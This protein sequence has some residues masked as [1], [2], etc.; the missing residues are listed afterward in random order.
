[1]SMPSRTTSEAPP[2]VV[3]AT[4]R[5]ASPSDCE[6][7][8]MAGL[9][10]MNDMS[11][12]S[13]NSASI[14]SVPELN[15]VSSMVDVVADGGL[16]EAFFDAD[17]RR[18]VGDVREVAKTER[19]GLAAAHTLGP[20]RSAR[21]RGGGGRRTIGLG[22]PVASVPAVVVSAAVPSAAVALGGGGRVAGG[23]VVVVTA[24]GGEHEKG[25]HGGGEEASSNLSCMVSFLH[26]G[27]CF[28][29]VES[30]DGS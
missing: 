21:G 13:A 9:G 4:M 29:N 19:D 7:P 8:L 2:D 6:Y 26:G 14:A 23:S 27:I 18:G 30:Y 24:A 10:P 25:D 16:E 5:R 20:G 22:V 3:P 15:V 28:R 12:A 17:D 11:M 1:M